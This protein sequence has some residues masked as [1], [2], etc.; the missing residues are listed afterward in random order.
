M[1]SS[2]TNDDGSVPFNKALHHAPVTQRTL[3]TPIFSKIAQAGVPWLD[4]VQDFLIK[5]DIK[6]LMRLVFFSLKNVI[7]RLTKIMNRANKN[8]GHF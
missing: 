5:L 6:R 3:W 2:C 1:A 7:V 8:W 4:T